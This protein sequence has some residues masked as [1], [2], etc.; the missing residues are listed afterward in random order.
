MRSIFTKNNHNVYKGTRGYI[1]GG[2]MAALYNGTFDQSG[3]D[4]LTERLTES[5]AVARRSTHIPQT[6]KETTLNDRLTQAILASVR[7]YS[8]KKK[9]YS[10]LGKALEEFMGDLGPT[11]V[12]IWTEKQYTRDEMIE[13]ASYISHHVGPPCFQKRLHD[14]VGGP[15]YTEAYNNGS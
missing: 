8:E 1:L 10:E 5:L 2:N 11:L 15:I 3:E 9:G 6:W 13:R 4:T 7:K 14:Q 12:D